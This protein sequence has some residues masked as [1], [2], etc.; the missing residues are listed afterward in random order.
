[1]SPRWQFMYLRSKSRRLV[2]CHMPMQ[3]RH[4]RHYRFEP[5]AIGVHE[6][7]PWMPWRW[8][9][10]PRLFSSTYVVDK[11]KQCTLTNNLNLGVAEWRGYSPEELLHSQ[12][13]LLYI[14]CTVL[15]SHFC[16][17]M[18]FVLIIPIANGIDCSSGF[19]YNFFSCEILSSSCYC[20]VLYGTSE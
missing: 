16:W 17:P 15:R 6:T 5:Q 20:T 9:W 2:V 19:A 3:R 18:A 14:A 4:R 7:S 12:H 10:S 13:I 1:M 11:F 8:T